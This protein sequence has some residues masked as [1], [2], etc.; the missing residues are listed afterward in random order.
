MNLN[1]YISCTFNCSPNNHQ[2]R[3]HISL[4]S[5][6]LISKS[7][8]SCQHSNRQRSNNTLLPLSFSKV[9]L[10]PVCLPSSSPKTCRLHRGRH[11]RLLHNR[12]MLALQCH[13]LALLRHNSSQGVTS[14][15]NLVQSHS[16]C[17]DIT[18]CS[19]ALSR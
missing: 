10:Y 8:H 12:H 1:R 2:Q 19:R 15:S 9:A 4:R 6:K 17:R 3:N 18:K 5:L 11:S 7:L 13:R 14:N 16:N